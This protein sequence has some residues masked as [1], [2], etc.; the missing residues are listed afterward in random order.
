MIHLMKAN[1]IRL[2][3]NIYFGTGCII[4]VAAT[5]WFSA[6]GN[7]FTVFHAD[8]PGE[9]M[10]LISAAMLGFF[11]TFSTIFIN[12][13]YSDGVIR[14]KI[15]AGHSQTEI[16]LSHLVTQAFAAVVMN[17]CWILGGLLGG[18]KM[19]AF[20]LRYLVIILFAEFAF[21]SL[22]TLCGMRIKKK[23][24]AGVIGVFLFYLLFQG[25]MIGNAVVSFSDGMFHKVAKIVYHLPPLGQWF[26]HIYVC[27]PEFRFTLAVEVSLSLVCCLVCTLS[28]IFRI[29]KREHV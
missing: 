12:V 10:I 21:V 1:L 27:E 19:D 25:V 28:G 3:H 6:C 16:Y 8:T 13:E 11:A 26:S 22:L 23:M 4:A 9:L 29:G 24:C 17:V 7:R 2:F 18:A 15:I 14:N 20:L 5:A